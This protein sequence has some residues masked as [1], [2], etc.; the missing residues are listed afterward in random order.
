MTIGGLARILNAELVCPSGQAEE[1]F[2]SVSLDSRTSG[3]GALFVAL[4]G[5]ADDGH[6]YV[7]RALERGARAALVCRASLEKN[8]YGLRDGGSVLVVVDD[9][10]RALQDAARIYLEQFPG[11]L[12]IGITGS[13]GKTTTKEIAG[14]IIGREKKVVMNPGN[15]NSETGLPLA[16]FNVQDCHEVGIFEMGMNRR[17]EIAELAGILKPHIALIT[18]T[19]TA[20]IGILGTK[21]AIAREKKE[22]FS[23]FTGTE[24]ALVP[25]ASE[26]AEFLG[27]DVNG[28]VKY[29]GQG[30]SL[31]ASRDLGLSGT[32]LIWEGTAVRFGL[33]G[34]Y[35]LANA[36]AAAALAAEVPVSVGAIRQ[37]LESVKPLSGRGEICSGPVTVIKD[38]YN[39]NPEA[40]FEALGFADS[41]PWEGRKLYVIG[42]MLELGSYSE[43]AHRAVGKALA[44]S[45]ADLVFLFGEETL[46]CRD[47][48]GRTETDNTGRAGTGQAETGCTE[49]GR[50][51]KTAAK[52]HQEWFYSGSMDELAG[53]LRSVLRPGDL[54]LLK[55]SRGTALE[56]LMAVIEEFSL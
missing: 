19:G 3:E 51:N 38:C 35:N 55:G 28:K 39:A 45:E 15:L 24:T 53:K 42:A 36:L 5:S 37:G 33:P 1:R 8:D 21:E 44:G 46:A 52:S 27:R 40:V 32:E 2:S 18:N 14:A 13:S 48:A 4:K 6:R 11:L 41:V 12:K 50:D 23:R 16:V 47:G 17:G 30:A 49:T 10:L 26:F 25:A 29:Y 20:H 56:R 22:I 7:S 54:V 31:E 43:E 9:T 34:R